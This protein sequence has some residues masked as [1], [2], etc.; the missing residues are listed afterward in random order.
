MPFIITRMDHDRRRQMDNKR[1]TRPLLS[2]HKLPILGVYTIYIYLYLYIYHTAGTFAQ[3]V[4]IW[5]AKY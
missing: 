5:K 3:H 4:F 1:S 2:A